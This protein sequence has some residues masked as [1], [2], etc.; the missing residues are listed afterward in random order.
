MT[1]LFGKQDLFNDTK[2]HDKSRQ[3]RSTMMNIFV[4]LR[5]TR[6]VLVRQLTCC[7]ALSLGS[8]KE[9]DICGKCTR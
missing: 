6:E 9:S 8:V 7:E 5:L 3:K 2:L 4:P 1:W